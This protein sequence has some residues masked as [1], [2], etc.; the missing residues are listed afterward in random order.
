M[1]DESSAATGED[2][3]RED[4]DDRSTKK[5]RM[6]E[7]VTEASSSIDVAMPNLPKS[8]KDKLTATPP[9]NQSWLEDDKEVPC[10]PGDI[11]VTTDGDIPSLELSTEFEQR[12]AKR[13]ERAVI[14]KLMGRN[15]SYRVLTEKLNAIWQPKGLFKVID[16]DNNFFVVKFS[17]DNDYLHSL[18]GS[19]WTLFRSLLCVMPWNPNF[20][21][22]TDTIDRAIV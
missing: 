1:G 20:C 14:V 11:I 17:T 19:P 10:G 22:A 5:S 7:G 15:I 21:A 12:L 8:Y 16:L 18:V 2:L 3:M 6:R 13:W 9:E 4:E